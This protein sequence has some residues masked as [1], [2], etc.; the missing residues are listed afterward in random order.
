MFRVLG[1][2]AVEVDGADLELS[3]QLLLL[4]GILLAERG[5]AVPIDV[6]VDRLWSGR[7]PKTANKVVHVVVGR[8]RRTLEEAGLPGCITTVGHGYRLQPDATDLDQY[9]AGLRDADAD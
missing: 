8:L 1:G 3:G 6:I 4:L 7:P 9:L 5:R 2:V